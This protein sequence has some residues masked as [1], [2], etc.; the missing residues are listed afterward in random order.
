MNGQNIKLILQQISDV[1]LLNGGFLS[2]PGLYTGEMGL[3]L[4]FTRYARFTEND[5]YPDYSFCLMENIQNRI[6]R[7]TS[8][9]YRE[10]LSGIGSSVEY[11]VQNGFIN[12]DT[13]EI[14]EDFDQRL[15]FTYSLANLPID[16]IIDIG[17]YAAWRMSGKS[18][19]KDM[20][21]RTVL[22]QIENRS[23]FPK[24]KHKTVPESFKE[25]THSHCLE[26]IA[27]NQFWDM[28]M[29]LQNGLAGW[30]LSLL[31]E[32]DGD[33]SWFSLLPD[34]LNTPEK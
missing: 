34:N 30:G 4:F 27:E 18:E 26:L 29:G 10:G 33:D 1:L 25:K 11:L 9:D 8:I 28:E 13:D 20:I 3:V 2:N 23:V 19:Q 5:L 32:I 21:R 15:F 17:Y 22:P 31:T 6:H 12:A 7:Q 24:L 16:E 14:L